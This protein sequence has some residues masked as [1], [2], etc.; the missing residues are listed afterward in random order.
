MSSLTRNK[1]PISRQFPWAQSCSE[2]MVGN[3]SISLSLQREWYIYILEP[4]SFVSAPI[5]DGI[6]CFGF[7][8]ISV[9]VCDW[10]R[11]SKWMDW[12][13]WVWTIDWFQSVSSRSVLQIA[14]GSLAV[15]ETYSVPHSGYD[16]NVDEQCRFAPIPSLFAIWIIDAIIDSC[17]FDNTCSLHFCSFIIDLIACC[18][19]KRV[20]DAK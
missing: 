19:L 11:I 10:D 2:C 7:A 12:E 1:W 6:S 3:T 9:V 17:F 4:I 8:S 18:P 15:V 14:Y 20:K 5:F 13:S 16:R